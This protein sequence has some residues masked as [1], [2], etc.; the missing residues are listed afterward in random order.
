VIACLGEENTGSTQ[1]SVGFVKIDV[2]TQSIVSQK[3][4]TSSYAAGDKYAYSPQM[5]S[6]FTCEQHNDFVFFLACK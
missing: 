6:F 1:G 4:Y 5:F 3:V 2:G